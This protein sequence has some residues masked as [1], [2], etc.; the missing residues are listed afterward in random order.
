MKR[1]IKLILIMLAVASIINIVSATPVAAKTTNLPV[2]KLPS[3]Y[4]VSGIRITD[5]CGKV[6]E[7]KISVRF[8]E[9]GLWQFL[10]PKNPDVGDN[11]GTLAY[12]VW[13]YTQKNHMSNFRS[14]VPK[15][16]DK[17]IS[18]QGM[19]K[20]IIISSKSFAGN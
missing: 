11:R 10:N 1:A 9:Y 3:Y 2:F 7:E 16:F 15:D 17:F 18:K 6:I 13:E 4:E 20:E 8:K 19:K 5:K 14:W 12:T